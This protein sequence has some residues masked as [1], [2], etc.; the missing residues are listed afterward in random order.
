MDRQVIFRDYQEQVATDHNNIQDYVR[1]AMDNIVTDAVSATRKYSGLMVTKTGQ[2]EVTVGM[3]RVYDTGAVY[4]LRAILTQSLATYVAAAA[5]RVV[6]ISAYGQEVQTD[7][8]T[9]DYLTDVDTGTVEPRA[10]AMTDSRD[11]QIVFTAGAEA[12]DPVPPAIPATHVVIANVVLDTTQIVSIDMQ[13]QNAVVSTDALDIRTDLL[14]TF[15]S[16]IEPRVTSL[17]SDLADLSNRITGLAAQDDLSR[18]YLDLARV[19]ESLRFPPDASGFDSDFFL[20]MNK[21]DYNNTLLLG[22][23]A[24]VEEGIRFNDANANQFEISLFSANDPNAALS[25]GYL[26]PKY[27]N[28]LKIQT[29]AYTES[30]GIAQY[31]YQVHSMQVGYMARTRIRYGGSYTVCTNGNSYN[32]PGEQ[33]NTTNLYDFNTTEFTTVENNPPTLAHPYAWSRTDYYWL[34]TWEEPFMYEVTTNLSI[35]GAQVAQTFLVSNDIIATQLGFYITA[36]AANED[37]HIALCEVTAGQPDL[38]KVCLKT[39]YSQASIVTGWNLCPIQPTFLQKGK[40]YAFVFISNANHQI[41]MT[42]G[43]SYLD[44]TFFYSTDG[45]Y[46]MGDL[47]KDMMLQVYGAS[48]ASSQVAIEFAPINLDGGFRDV[49]ILAEQWVPGSCELVFEMRPNG[50]GEW[51]PLIADNSGVLGTAPPLAQFRA[52]FIGTTDMA[53]I[54]H[55][56][57]SRVSVSR[58]KTAYKHVSTQMTVPALSNIAHNLTFVNLLEM[59]DPTPHTYGISVR[60]G[61]TEYTPDTT[62]TEVMDATAKRY[63]KTYTFSLPAGTTQF[64][65]EQTGTTNSPQVT[66]HVAERTFYTK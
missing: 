51:Q 41:G 39:T 53:P 65:I 17:A 42:S 7:V 54:L 37:I 31:G 2:V 9:R 56:T 32:T 46:Y 11:A 4:A 27:T 20:D 21:S 47:T 45:I 59:F 24:K 34:D 36:K 48:F 61:G 1:T 3:G 10:V 22:Y 28:V 15:K 43:Q 29:G 35:T 52:R 62:I 38:D 6:T 12:A 66:Y 64:T 44:G 40:R 50:T 5:R 58:P 23:D 49:D 60:V 19:K 63:Q 8:Q 33:V 14:E 26:M 25:G 55:L 57:G 16:L 13:D 30:L 18:V